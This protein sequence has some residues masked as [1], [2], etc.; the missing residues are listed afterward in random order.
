LYLNARATVVPSLCYEVSPLV[1]AESWSCG[2]PVIVRELGSL[3]EIVDDFGG[4]L[5]FS[6]TKEF[7]VQL[8][9][10]VAD[11]VLRDRLSEAARKAWSS[12]LTPGKHMERYME[13]IGSIRK[14]TQ[15][16][17]ATTIGGA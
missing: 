4:G 2:T 6:S 7:E 8:T 9:R 5:Y 3:K 16:I 10:L 17:T 12:H 11:D 14:E 13:I 1:I 15:S